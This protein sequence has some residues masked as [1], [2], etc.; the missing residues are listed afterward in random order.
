MANMLA[1]FHDIT[2]ELT[3]QVMCKLKLAIKFAVIVCYNYV[4]C[5]FKYNSI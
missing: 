4:V 5:V 1:R 2:T 3:S